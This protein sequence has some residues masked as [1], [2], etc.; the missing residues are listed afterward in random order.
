MRSAQVV[1]V[2]GERHFRRR[3]EGAVVM[4]YGS[5]AIRTPGTQTSV[6]VRGLECL[7]SYTANVMRRV[8]KQSN[9]SRS[10]VQLRLSSGWL[11]P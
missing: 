5:M 10:R 3:E 4:V 11:G 8:E 1:L 9:V 6:V 7:G 2:V